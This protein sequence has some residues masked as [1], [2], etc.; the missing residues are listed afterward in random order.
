M[1]NIYVCED[2]E[3]QR[4]KLKSILE[5]I[6]VMEE[7]DMEL[8]M[9]TE[10]PHEVL[11]Y[12]KQT[13]EV[14]IYFLDIDLKTDM[15]GLKL[16]SEI[17][18]YDPRGF[19]VFVTSHSEMSYMAFQYRL[20]AMDYIAKDQGDDIIRERVYHCLINANERFSSV[21]N[22]VQDIFKFKVNNRVFSIEYDD[23]IYFETSPNIHKVILHGKRRV[24]EFYGKIK[25]LEEKLDGRFY[26]S[27]RSF[28]LNKNNIKEVD[29]KEKVVIMVNGETCPISTRRIKGLREK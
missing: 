1:L 21:N 4:K 14:G 8:V 26:R 19:I 24:T 6:I 10:N 18:K 2:I 7:F 11:S 17:R 13:E 9:A 22:R 23:I 5:N 15:D 12:V 29:I 16:A 27:N 20:E 25:D 3:I 28:L